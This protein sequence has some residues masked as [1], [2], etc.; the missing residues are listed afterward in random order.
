VSQGSIEILVNGQP[1]MARI[2]QAVSEL[3][4]E[5][6]LDGRL[7]VVELNRQILRRGELSEVKLEPGDRVEL[8]N[9]VGGG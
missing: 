1:R 4:S 3:L 7:V 5:L 6:E 9:F 2:G 8:V